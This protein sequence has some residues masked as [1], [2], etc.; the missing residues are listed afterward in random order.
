M[1]FVFIC[2]SAAEDILA[3]G[4]E[5]LHHHSL[6][7]AEE[8]S[9]GQPDTD[10]RADMTAHHLARQRATWKRRQNK[11]RGQGWSMQQS[12]ESKPQKPWYGKNGTQVSTLTEL[13]PNNLYC[14][15]WLQTVTKH[16]LFITIIYYFAGEYNLYYT[17]MM[18]TSVRDFETGVLNLLLAK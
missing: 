17:S 10:S 5:S 11:R 7:P 4:K 18:W 3:T 1:Q 8:A 12:R 6:L 14:S 15:N 16:I 9:L 2:V 13:Y